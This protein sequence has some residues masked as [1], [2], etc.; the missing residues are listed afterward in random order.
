MIKWWNISSCVRIQQAVRMCKWLH[1]KRRAVINRQF[2]QSKLIDY[3]RFSLI[4][5]PV[6]CRQ[7]LCLTD[8]LLLT[9]VVGHLHSLSTQS[10]NMLQISGVKLLF[11]F[12][13][14]FYV[15]FIICIACSVVYIFTL[16]SR[17]CCFNK[18]IY[19]SIHLTN[20]ILTSPI[21]FELI[22]LFEQNLVHGLIKTS[23]RLVICLHK[24]K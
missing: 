13:F 23:P 19:L 5:H 10:S 21:L 3:T 7:D 1:N 18:K 22:E 9:T 2:R 16:L 24:T 14:L 17:D 15:F 4:Y 12:I 11:Q 6:Y 20:P 8:S